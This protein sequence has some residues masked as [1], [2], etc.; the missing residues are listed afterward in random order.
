M[1]AYGHCV[2][3][4]YTHSR[5]YTLKQL[6]LLLWCTNGVT[7]SAYFM[8]TCRCYNKKFFVGMYTKMPLKWLFAI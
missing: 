8:I 6:K 1:S 2:S 3:C 4:T 7:F 5:T